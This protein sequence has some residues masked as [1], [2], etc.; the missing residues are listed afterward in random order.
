M[1]ST[2]KA[3]FDKAVLDLYHQRRVHLDEHDYPAGLSDQQKEELVGEKGKYY[4]NIG[5]RDEAAEKSGKVSTS[6]QLSAFAGIDVDGLV[7]DLASELSAELKA[8]PAEKPQVKPE[9]PVT[10]SAPR[11]ES[12]GNVG[13]PSVE[14]TLTADADAELAKM[15]AKI[16]ARKAREGGEKPKF[17]KPLAN[18]PFRP[19][20]PIRQAIRE[21]Q[22]I[23]RP[24]H[25]LGGIV[26]GNLQAINLLADIG[27]IQRNTAATAALDGV[28]LPQNVVRSVIGKLNKAIY[29]LQFG[30]GS[31][32][33]LLRLRATL[34][35]AAREGAVSIVD[36]GAGRTLAQVRAA[37]R[38]ELH[39]RYEKDLTPEAAREFLTDPLAHKASRTL[40]EDKDY[41]DDPV[42]LVSEIGAH[43][44]AGQWNDLD[45][46]VEQAKLLWQK[47]LATQPIDYNA[48]QVHPVLR[49]ATHERRPEGASKRARQSDSGSARSGAQTPSDVGRLRGG[50]EGATEESV[51]GRAGRGSQAGT[52]D[53]RRLSEGRSAEESLFTGENQQAAS[54]LES[55]SQREPQAEK[56]LSPG[57]GGAEE[58][59]TPGSPAVRRT[60]TTAHAAEE[61][62]RAAA[63][64]RALLPATPQAD[65]ED[66]KSL[67]RIGAKHIVVDK[68]TDYDAWTKLLMQNAGDVVADVAEQANL[69][70]D[71]LQQQVYQVARAIADRVGATAKA[72]KAPT[73][74]PVQAV[75][76]IT[77]AE[78]RAANLKRIAEIEAELKA[79]GVSVPAVPSGKGQQIAAGLR[80]NADGMTAQIEAQKNPA[81]ANQNPTARRAHIAAGMAARGD[82]L[83]RI[84]KGLR[85]LADL[86]ESGEVP[87]VLQGVRTRSAFEAVMP[88]YDERG[89]RVRDTFR[90]ASL[91]Q[92]DVAE[93]LE[94]SKGASGTAE[95][96][97]ILEGVRYAEVAHFREDQIPAI[98]KV[99]D[100]A[101]KR[102]Y[103]DKWT[104]DRITAPKKLYAIGINEGNFTAAQDAID[105]LG[106]KKSEPTAEQKIRAAE[107]ELLG[108]KILAISPRRSHWPRAW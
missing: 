71:I 8:A 13:T 10:K 20:M 85:A 104:R 46:T 9:T 55:Q 15:R 41:D 52:P 2:D 69:P 62:D 22:L 17:L 49:E 94:K 21:S 25:N 65:P 103:N 83:E 47:Y 38:H 80:R 67:A 18:K 37:V 32:L 1:G 59:G 75:Q 43:L 7:D 98:E 33:P 14:E 48:E 26:Y 84:Q 4:V 100:A 86:H 24:E 102:G 87:E 92:H 66:L 108:T 106:V 63:I 89:Q 30:P 73:A 27:A 105:A 5:L 107:R 72:A 29:T 93:L 12:G 6:A 101:V 45:L 74:T 50:G 81:I 34:L 16:A 28:Y 56:S 53:N 97:R 91:T 96:R 3:A 23:Y 44:R 61:K 78:K 51:A 90:G 68:A 76:P 11:K 70:V 99:M 95:G 64:S 79:K 58:N 54:G 82:Y 40:V 36:A 77:D 88:R 35:A 42:E 39:H 31:L 57:V 19:D 60:G